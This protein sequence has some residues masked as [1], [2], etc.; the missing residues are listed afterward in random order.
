[1]SIKKTII[2]SILSPERSPTYGDHQSEMKTALYELW[3]ACVR[4]HLEYSNFTDGLV[5]VG[6]YDY[7]WV[8]NR[9]TRYHQ[10]V[11]FGKHANE[12]QRQYLNGLLSK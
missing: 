3:S 10:S 5:V 8:S 12:G 2:E 11:I 9:F 6:R 7:V 4:V 1:M